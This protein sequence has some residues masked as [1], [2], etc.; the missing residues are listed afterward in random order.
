MDFSC[1]IL[2]FGE[3]Q[4]RKNRSYGGNMFGNS[5]TATATSST[6]NMF[7]LMQTTLSVVKSRLESSSVSTVICTDPCHDPL[8]SSMNKNIKPK[9]FWRFI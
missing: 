1:S 4:V 6:Y 5:G 7:K 2:S 3:I 9:H 8:Y